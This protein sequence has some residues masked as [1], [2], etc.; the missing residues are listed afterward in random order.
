[1]SKIKINSQLVSANTDIKIETLGLKIKNK[2]KYT[3]NN[4]FVTLEILSNKIKM[5]RSTDDYILILEFQKG[6]SIITTYDIKEIG[7]F[8]IEVET[9]QLDIKN[10]NIFIIYNLKIENEDFVK[11]TY[12]LKYQFI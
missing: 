8:D 5:I 10:N 12:N 11:F 1:M 6:K 7:I 2:F 9:V 3:E 4:V